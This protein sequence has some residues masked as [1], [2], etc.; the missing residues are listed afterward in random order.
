VGS[1]TAFSAAMTNTGRRGAAM[2]QVE[3][4][5]G[6]LAEIVADPDAFKEAEAAVR[7]LDDVA[8]I[9]ILLGKNV[10]LG[11]PTPLGSHFALCHCMAGRRSGIELAA[12]RSSRE[13]AAV[14][15][16]LNSEASSCGRWF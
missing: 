16:G 7:I 12:P 3:N 2:V 11:W 1:F 4:G 5:W 9:T 14:G 15:M 10:R 8:G 6:T 13:R